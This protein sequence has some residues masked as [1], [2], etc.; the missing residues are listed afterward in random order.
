M[1]KGKAK[2]VH[3]I[4]NYTIQRYKIYNIL[5]AIQIQEGKFGSVKLKSYNTEI[6]CIMYSG[7]AMCDG[8]PEETVTYDSRRC[9]LVPVQ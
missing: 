5:Y 8:Q 2:R 7:K 3:V 1:V 9:R 6:V 4:I